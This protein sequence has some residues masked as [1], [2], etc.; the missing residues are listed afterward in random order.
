[1]KRVISKPIVY[2]LARWDDFRTVEIA[3]FV[4]EEAK[5]SF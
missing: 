2:W 3:D 1:M 4:Y 5:S